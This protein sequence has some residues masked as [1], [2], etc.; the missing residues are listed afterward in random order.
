M[1]SAPGKTRSLCL[2][3][4]L[5]WVQPLPLCPHAIGSGCEANPPSQTH[6]K[7]TA[8]AVNCKRARTG[9]CVRG[10]GDWEW[11][12]KKKWGGWWSSCRHDEQ[13][14][15]RFIW[16]RAQ[17]L[18]SRLAPVKITLYARWLDANPAPN[19]LGESGTAGRDKV[20]GCRGLRGAHM[21]W[22]CP[23]WFLGVG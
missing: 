20:I 16:E 15:C 9:T 3:Y 12:W 8:K 13:K 6:S 2:L 11:G 7:W 23:V 4:W 10:V 14:K 18:A 19:R 1:G 22:V 5:V 21:R 17:Q